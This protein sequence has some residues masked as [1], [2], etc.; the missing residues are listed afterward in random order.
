MRKNIQMRAELQY[1]YSKQYEGQWVAALYELS[2]W[3]QL[4]VS[5]QWLYNI[6]HADEANNEHYYTIGAAYTHGAHRVMA[7]YTKTREGYNCSGGICR[8]V[9]AQE[10]ITLTYNFTW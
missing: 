7:G 10:G 8:K 2:L 6:G 4:V 3:R 1:L 9:P 5:G